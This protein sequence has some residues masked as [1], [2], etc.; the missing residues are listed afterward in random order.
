MK[1]LLSKYKNLLESVLSLSTLNM[2]NMVLPLVTMPYMLP[3]V[4][5]E[6]YGIYIYVY[7]IIQYI[8]LVSCYGF[9]FSATKQIAQVR[10]DIHKVSSIY[11]D[12]TF[13]KLFLA[14]VSIVFV[15][16]LSPWLFSTN[17]EV[18]IYLMGLGIVIGDVF[19]PSWLYQGM[20]KMRYITYVNVLSKMLFTV[21]IFIVVKESDDYRYIILLN[22]L[23]FLL[24]GI[25]STIIAFKQFGMKL[26]VPT[27]NGIKSQLKEG[28]AIFGSTLS[29]E[30]YKN[31]N[32]IL[33]KFFMG[34][35]YVGIY[36]VAERI[37]KGIRSAATPISHA[38]FP[39]FGRKFVGQ[40]LYTN[41]NLLGKASR[42]L[43]LMLFA[44][45]LV[46]VLCAHYICALFGGE[47]FEDTVPL[48]YILSPVIVLGGLNYVLGFVGL[49]NLGYQKRFFY[50]V[51]T[52]GILSVTFLV[53][54]VHWWGMYAAAIAMTLSE[55]ILF[56]NCVIFLWNK[57]NDCKK[58]H[59]G[60]NE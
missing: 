38:L 30:L 19:N 6:K 14:V 27:L 39:H 28:S 41:V 46:T 59:N 34:E 23:G 49:V 60:T 3:I 11:S 8:M 29:I 37:I 17:D 58:Q 24:A 13:A 12:V 16:L 44:L 42:Y 55:L 4:G 57:Y 36:S 31:S 32:V 10:E 54:C 21:L 20:E 52:S 43:G 2:L 51:M 7:T 15:F 26:S 18:Q 56:V 45:M 53:M 25:V 5:P 47:A 35:Y 40:S 1:R 9:P 33:L 48:M 50:Y 22:S